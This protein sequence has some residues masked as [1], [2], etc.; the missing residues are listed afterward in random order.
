MVDSGMPPPCS[1]VQLDGTKHRD[2]RQ[3]NN[4]WFKPAGVGQ[5][6]PRIDELADLY[7]QRMRS[8]G[9]PGAFATEI[10]QPEQPTV[11]RDRSRGHDEGKADVQEQQPDGSGDAR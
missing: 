11:T 1:L 7:I 3:V 5:R 8:R 2:H 9:D 10:A 4:D 6:K